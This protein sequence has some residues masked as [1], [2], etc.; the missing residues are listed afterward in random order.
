MVTLSEVGSIP[1]VD[2]LQKDAAAWS[3]FMPWYGEFTR[4]GTHNSLDLWKKMFASEYV[5]TLDEMP[6][7]KN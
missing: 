5:V 2:N 4:N 6:D 7:L 1:E 3:W